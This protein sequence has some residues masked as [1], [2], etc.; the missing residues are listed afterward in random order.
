MTLT[1]SAIDIETA[2]ANRAS[3]CQIGIVHVRDGVI[4]DHWQSLVNP[5]AWF[6]PLNVSIHGIDEKDVKDSPSFSDIREELDRLNGSILIS[7]TSFDRVSVERA[8]KEHNLDPLRVTWLDST[9][10][11]RRAWPEQYGR[12]GWGL[13]NVATDLGITFNHHDALED[14]RA[15]AEIVLRACTVTGTG[16]ADW[17]HLVD[18]PIFPPSDSA[19]ASQSK[20]R[21]EPKPEANP[22]GSLYGETILFTG[23]LSIP[24][25]EASTHAAQA[26]CSVVD[27]ASKKVTMLVVGMQDE[28][29]LQG[30]EKSSKHRKIEALISKGVGI[31]VLSESDF[32]ELIGVKEPEILASAKPPPRGTKKERSEVEMEVVFGLGQASTFEDIGHGQEYE[33]YIYE[34]ADVPVAE[35]LTYVSGTSDYLDNL[36]GCGMDD[37]VALVR[38]LKAE[39]ESSPVVVSCKG[40]KIG[41]LPRELARKIGA[42]LDADGSYEAFLED[43]WEDIEEGDVDES[44]VGLF[45][46]INLDV[47]PTELIKEGQKAELPNE[48]SLEALRKVI[49]DLEDGL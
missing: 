44:D 37:P 11:V 33:I 15:A 29:K 40:N 17:L 38:E 21:S 1:F 26:G 2:N 25:R 34:D 4:T 35:V 5:S 46:L 45:V 13:K 22:D 7:H 48:E 31:D 39:E 49:E 6:D 14:A 9:R 36:D 42:H 16:I 19:S 28:S 32:Y 47:M 23:R 24:R 43:D 3:I 8:L 18:Q 41:Y 30:Y 10:I 20:A 27:S 12:S